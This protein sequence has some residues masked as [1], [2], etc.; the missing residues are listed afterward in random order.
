[1]NRAFAWL[2]ALAAL[3]FS[4]SAAAETRSVP[5]SDPPALEELRIEAAAKDAAVCLVAPTKR[6]DC[7][8][9]DTMAIQSTVRALVKAPE[10]LLAVAVVRFESG[11]TAMVSVSRQPYLGA[12]MTDVE[13]RNFMR[14]IGDAA[15][16]APGSRHLVEPQRTRVAG[17]EAVAFSTVRNVDG[18]TIRTETRSL[19]A[20]NGVY[21]VMITGPSGDTPSFR[22]LT[23]HV[24]GSIRFAPGNLRGF[25]EPS[26]ALDSRGLLRIFSFGIVVATIAF[27]LERRARAWMP[28]TPMTARA[29]QWLGAM[30]FIGSI[31]FNI[32]Q[33]ERATKE[34]LAVDGVLALL[35]LAAAI[36]IER[37]MRKAAAPP[38]RKRKR[39]KLKP[40][41][42]PA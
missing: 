17:A 10:V 42:T 38:K 21:F 8:D 41:E 33:A 30:A 20:E 26:R 34:T 5:V 40:G 6:G 29:I 15:V 14:E 3:L 1:V 4:L 22:A 23:D 19:F 2:A 24:F 35:L 28:P 36:A 27:L 37:V 11:E 7:D 12:A 32:V 9:V 16:K 39:K 25:G 31:L 13:L 18:E